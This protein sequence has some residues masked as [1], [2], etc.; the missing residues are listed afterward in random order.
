M[1]RAKG[2]RL[3]RGRVLLVCDNV[4]A[5]KAIFVVSQNFTKFKVQM[6]LKDVPFKHQKQTFG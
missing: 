6:G 1:H 3:V 2:D 4:L 5:Q